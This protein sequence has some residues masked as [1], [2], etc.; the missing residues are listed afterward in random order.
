MMLNKIFEN[1]NISLKTRLFSIKKYGNTSSASIPITISSSLSGKKI[2]QPVIL[3]GFGAGF[4]FAACIVRL[5]K[6]KIFKVFK[7]EK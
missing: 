2:N 5:N 6:A 3:A 7:Y 4:S 1:L